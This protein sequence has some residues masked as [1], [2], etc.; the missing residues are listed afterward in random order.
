[1]VIL[2][3]LFNDWQ[4]V[5]CRDV[6]IATAQ[7]DAHAWQGSIQPLVVARSEDRA[8][9]VSRAARRQLPFPSQRSTQEKWSALVYPVVTWVAVLAFVCFCT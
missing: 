6:T 7:S 9:G 2:M 5:V 4:P 1:M 3:R 8:D